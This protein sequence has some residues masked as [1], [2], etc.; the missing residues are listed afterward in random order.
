MKVHT[1]L[2]HHNI[3]IV[4]GPEA[5]V[6][7]PGHRHQNTTTTQGTKEPEHPSLPRKHMITKTTKRR[8]ELHALLAGFAA[9]PY[10]NYSNHPMISR[11]MMDLKS[12][13]HGSHTIYKQ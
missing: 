12:H 9:L 6:D 10:P 4:L 5:G 2:D 7:D 8:W 3:T 1:N 11:N 13:S